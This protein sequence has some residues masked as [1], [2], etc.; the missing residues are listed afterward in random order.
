MVVLV[1]MINLKI[2]LKTHFV[3]WQWPSQP[4]PASSTPSFGSKCKTSFRL[5][6]SSF[7]NWIIYL[8]ACDL[9]KDYDLNRLIGIQLLCVNQCWWR[10]RCLCKWIGNLDKTIA[11][12]ALIAWDGMAVWNR[13]R[14]HFQHSISFRWIVFDTHLPEP[15]LCT[16]AE[17]ARANESTV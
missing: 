3:L 6:L 16:R 7:A 1:P 15:T 4:P 5:V 12:F 11:Q 8:H 10:G 14:T 13:K 9:Q 2:P 17:R